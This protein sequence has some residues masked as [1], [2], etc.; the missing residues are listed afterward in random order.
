MALPHIEPKADD[1]L[2]EVSGRKAAHVKKK[3][4]APTKRRARFNPAHQ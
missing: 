4:N 3:W 2:N 1:E